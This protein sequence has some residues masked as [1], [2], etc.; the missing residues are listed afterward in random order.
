MAVGLAAIQQSTHGC[1]ECRR[2]NNTVYISQGFLDPSVAHLHMPPQATIARTRDAAG[3]ARYAWVNGL[4]FDRIS[5]NA[6]RHASCELGEGSSIQPQET[7]DGD[8]LAGQAS[9]SA[10]ACQARYRGHVQLPP[11]HLAPVD[12][13]CLDF[14]L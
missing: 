7:L 2:G 1:N 14:A 5:L 4:C 13:E 3:C 9:N 6:L 11:V 10:V 8:I 12:S